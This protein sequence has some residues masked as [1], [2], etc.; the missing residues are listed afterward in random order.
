MTYCYT[1]FLALSSSRVG[2]FFS[3]ICHLGLV[4]RFVGVALFSLPS[5]PWLWHAFRVPGLDGVPTWRSSHSHPMH[6]PGSVLLD[7][8]R[9]VASG[10]LSSRG[11]RAGLAPSLMTV[12]LGPCWLMPLGSLAV[13]S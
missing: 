4:R 12:L 7:P 10:A 5:A 3:G 6:M 2:F 13:Q 11:H 8:D 9:A 1:L